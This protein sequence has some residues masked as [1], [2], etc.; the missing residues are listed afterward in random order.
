MAPVLLNM[1]PL[2]ARFSPFLAVAI[3]WLWLMLP[4]FV[5]SSVLLKRLSW[6]ERV[7]V[8]FMLG[9]GLA[10]PYT[11]LA[12]LLRVTL[13]HLLG[14]SIGMFVLTVLILLIH[15]LRSRPCQ[16][17]RQDET[18]EVGSGKLDLGL[19][20]HVCLPLLVAGLIAF[21]SSQWPPA[22]D[23][24][25]GLPH[26]AEVL[27][28]GQITGSEPFHGTG[29][30]VTP[31]NELIVWGYQNILLCKLAGTSPV[32][33]F[34]NSRPI[35]VVLAFLAL[36]T[37]LH[38]SF[39]ER[40]QALFLLSLWSIYLL[41]TTQV[42]GTGSDL[43]TRSIQDKFQGWF[44]VAPIVLV[45]MQWFL[46]SRRPRYLV[47]FGVG[48]FGCALLH[49][50]TL[51]QVAI[52]A[53]SYGALYLACERSKRAL[54]SLVSVAL[55]LVLCLA[56]PV[57]QYLRYLAPMPIDLA[58]L[59]DAV[60]F[61]RLSMA[62]SRY[63]LWLL[64]GDRYI[65]HPSIVLRPLILLGYLLSP[66]L[67][68]RLRQSNA[69]RFIIAS[70]VALPL[71]LYVPPLAAIVGKFVTPFLLWRLAW[72]LPLLSVLTIGWA[73]WEALGGA[74][75]LVRRHSIRVSAVLHGVGSLAAIGLAL[76][77]AWPDVKRGLTNFRERLSAE[78]FSTCSTARTALLHLDQLAHDQPVDVLA[79]RSLNFCIPAYAAMANVVEFRGY[80]TVNRLPA[81]LI[82]DS[83]Q[84]VEDATYF[85]SAIV[86]DDLVV[87]A[88]KRYDIDYVLVEKDRL[89]LDLQLRHLPTMF[90]QVYGDR[91][92]ALYAVTKPL[93]PSPIVDGNAML[94]RCRWDEAE[95]IFDQI[96][97]KDPPQV[98]ADLGLGMAHEG[99]GE[100]AQALAAYLE[101][102]R[103]A[104]SEPALH[105]RV[106]ETY[107][108]MREP[109][110]AADEYERAVALAS[111]RHSLHASLG[112]AYLLSGRQSAALRSYQQASALQAAEGTAVYYSVLG[113]AT[114]SA[115]WASQAIQSYRTAIAIEPDAARYADLARALAESADLV[116][117]IQANEKTIQ[118]DR[119]LDTPHLQLG[120]IYQS[121]GQL[122]TAI[123][124]YERALR[125]NPAN[126][127]A[128]ISLGQAIREKSG[129][130][131]AIA[132]LE[133]LLSLHRVL[134]G[135]HRALAPLYAADG[136]MEAALRELDLS[137]SIQ[138]RD[139]SIKA[140]VGDLLR[141]NGHIDEAWQAYDE[142]LTINPALLAARIRLSA[143]YAREA[144]SD[145]QIGQ[146]LW[147]A[148]STLAAASPHLVLAN[149]YQSQ[150]EWEAA[151]AEIDWAI[152]LDPN[153]PAGYTAMGE[154][155]A[156]RAEWEVALR[157]YQRALALEPGRAEAYVQLAQAYGLSGDP[158][159]ARKVLE[160]AAEVKPHSA[161]V[162]V[163]LGDE[164]GRQGDLAGAIAQYH[165]AI[166]AEPGYVTAYTALANA[167]QAGGQSRA[168][169]AILQEAA[170]TVP[171]SPDSYS[172]LARIG[173]TQGR[174]DEAVAWARKG[175]AASPYAGSTYMA[176]AEEHK[177]TGAWELAISAYQR[178]TAVEPLLVDGY[179][180][181]GALYEARGD[182]TAAEAQFR[183]GTRAVPGAGMGHVALGD[184]Y[185]R[186]G[187]T[188][189]AIEAYQG[190]QAVAP[191]Y[192]DGPV[193]RWFSTRL[194]RGP[195]PGPP[196]PGSNWA[197]TINSRMR[198]RTSW[199]PMS[200]QLRWNRGTPWPGSAWARPTRPGAIWPGRA[201]PIG[202]PWLWN[203][204]M[205]R[206]IWRWAD[207]RNREGTPSLQRSCTARLLRRSQAMSLVACAWGPSTPSEEGSRRGWRS[208]TALLA[209]RRLPCRLLWSWGIGIA[210]GASGK[211][212][213]GRTVG[214]WKW[215]RQM[216]V[217]MWPSRS[218][219]RPG[220]IGLRPRRRIC[221]PLM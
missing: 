198:S 131:L 163:A 144:R 23:D 51:A 153:D 92:Y 18:P 194:L 59:G 39:K 117:A 102:S 190:A 168:A 137:C 33:F 100:I 26:F 2:T 74:S 61:A 78:A 38:Q 218:S 24:I 209:W 139:A 178:A 143:L 22:G 147:V 86:V 114:M 10:T 42:E 99:T 127:S 53:A 16:V 96:L 73:I 184:Y 212:Q 195:A 126:H 215:A 116:G 172:A 174:Y 202:K 175:V 105:A 5:L 14:M 129:I 200:E 140:A 8:S 146:L 41:A 221:R 120:G 158:A 128:F 132:R 62:V 91:D 157:A 93:P 28:L 150:G 151:Q 142:A 119:W 90:T 81:E 75:G 48:A 180:R 12:I 103:Q 95:E 110:Q 9:L 160:R 71:L 83:L 50:I 3:T 182:H 106:A 165:R 49:P 1:A 69:A 30:P 167:Y 176:L 35:L 124:E 89:S 40:H 206:S 43:I 29:T 55:V 25:A 77:I 97:Q 57:V 104:G 219:T 80:G 122:D 141:E 191:T 179:T 154:F 220:G 138:P 111:E 31:R 149:A 27:R 68:L 211:R 203:R 65:L 88:I 45:F 56:I 108:L 63:R 66:L 19:I 101:A 17:D 159:A 87:T 72:P 15:N 82:P 84:R 171:G 185:A 173:Q 177:R 183:A 121:Q 109:Q 60:E 161:E 67:L 118:W 47:G 70:M 7:P 207:L 208:S 192:L 123:Q 13:D 187:A 204:G 197:T 34:M 152:K 164:Y 162:L 213:S 107:L 4:G 196:W 37:F 145:L 79:S 130:A 85:S 186:R 20:P 201:T 166:E 199:W 188:A 52:L 170:E 58:G 134:P 44:I 32:S 46:E 54:W 36:Y 216:R 205:L 76:V 169:T 193:R 136:E 133:S 148:R 112:L 125:L 156:S 181:L 94:R 135:P 11:I 115:N 98:L 155:H 210:T 6:L 64:D 217:H 214:R 113:D 189:R 21:L